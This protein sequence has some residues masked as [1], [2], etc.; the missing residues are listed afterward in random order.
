MTTITCINNKWSKHEENR[1]GTKERSNVDLQSREYATMQ[2]V[3][4]VSLEKQ[5]I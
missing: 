4:V 1:N 2:G 3:S 5:N